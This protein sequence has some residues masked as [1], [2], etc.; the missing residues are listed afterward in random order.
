MPNHLI[1][2]KEL[3]LLKVG[4]CN[5]PEFI[6]Q[7]GGRFKFCQY[8]SIVALI[9]HPSKGY[10]LF[11]TGYAQRF[12]AETEHFPNKFY[13]LITPMHLPKNENLINQLKLRNICTAEIRSIF[14]S[15]FHA[16]HIAGLRDFPNATFYC[17]RIAYEDF[18]QR[19]GISAIIKGYLKNLL[20]DDF[21]QRVIFFEQSTPVKIPKLLHPFKRAYDLF[22]DGSCYVIC[23][24]GHAYGHHGLVYHDGSQSHFLIGDATWSIK[25]IQNQLKPN[26]IAMLIMSH[27]QL[28]YQTLSQL[29]KLHSNTQDIQLIPSHCLETYHRYTNA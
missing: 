1:Q 10:L 21:K 23:L 16:D 7:Q 14:I 12:N 22:N 3:Q 17:S 19:R 25:S 15:H 18:M 29:A 2:N 11:D 26:P 8:P 4:H 28:Y 27:K 13:R 6:V 24:P 5:H 9:N 20:P